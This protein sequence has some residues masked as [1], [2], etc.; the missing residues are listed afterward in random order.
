MFKIWGSNLTRLVFKN[1]EALKRLAV[2]TEQANKFR[3][4]YTEKNTDKKGF[5]FVKDE[6]IYLMNAYAGGVPPNEL[7]TVVYAE[8]F[9]PK[10]ENVWE[11]SRQAVG[12]DDFGEF[13]HISAKALKRI[14]DGQAEQVVIDM[15][16]DSY[17]V[18]V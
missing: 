1:G 15:M 9:H 8:G 4:P 17:A 2:G 13:I 5:L 10:D 11:K 16:P 6:G 3:I 14:I 7:G 12:G 18:E